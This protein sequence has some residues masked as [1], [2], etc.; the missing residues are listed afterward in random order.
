MIIAENENQPYYHQISGNQI[1]SETDP[2]TFAVD[3][4]QNNNI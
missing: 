1:Q 3:G 4:A 2:Q